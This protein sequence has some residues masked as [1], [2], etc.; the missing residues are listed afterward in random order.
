VLFQF[1]DFEIDPTRFE[2]RRAGAPV[3]IPRLVF[4]LLLYLAQHRDRPVTKTELL[5]RVWPGRT[6]TEAS[7]TQAITAARRA[8]AD[9]PDA[10][11]VI[12]T[13]HGRG[14]WWV[15]ETWIGSSESGRSQ[16]SVFVGRAPEMGL[17]LQALLQTR[18]GSSCVLRVVGDPGIGKSTF[19]KEVARSARGLGF[20]VLNGR[21]P[22]TNGESTRSPWHEVLRDAQ[23]ALRGFASPSAIN[24]GTRLD[25]IEQIPRVVRDC[26]AS[27]PTLIV[28]DDLHRVDRLSFR[29]LLS[30]LRGCEPQPLM[31]LVAQREVPQSHVSSYSEELRHIPGA[32]SI[33]LPPL[34]LSEVKELVDRSSCAVQRLDPGCLLARSGG[35]PFFATELLR[36]NDACAMGG[37]TNEAD[38]PRTVR[39]AIRNQ[40]RVLSP[41]ATTLLASAAVLGREFDASVLT[42][43]EGERGQPVLAPLDELFSAG[44]LEECHGQ[45][46][47]FRF[48]HV[49]VREAVYADLPWGERSRLHLAAAR[50]IR[51]RNRD[52]DG[53]H[54]LP[55]AHH[56]RSALPLSSAV[57]VAEVSLRAARFAMTSLEPEGAIECCRE[58][59]DLLEASEG[60]S[61]E[62]RLDL[63]IALAVAQLRAGFRR[64][65]KATLGKAQSRALAAGAYHQVARAA[66]SVAPGFFS[67]ETGVVNWDLISTLEHALA[68]LPT[69]ASALR[70]QLLSRLA[71]ALYWSEDRARVV[72]LVRDAGKLAKESASTA[73]LAYATIARYGAL[74]G[75][76]SLEERSRGADELRIMTARLGDAE[77]EMMGAVFRLTTMLEQ[78]ERSKAEDEMRVLRE[79]SLH[80]DCVLGRWYP[81]M[82]EAMTAIATGRFADAQGHI[83]RYHAIGQRLDDVNVSQTCLLQMTEIMWQS[84]RAAQI[85][86]AVRQN[87]EANPSLHEWRAAL[88]FLSARAGRRR[89]AVQGLAELSGRPLAGLTHRM[90]AVIGV[91]ALGE[92][93]WLLSDEEAAS[94][95]RPLLEKWGDRIIVAGYGVLSWGSTTRVRGHLAAVLGDFE[96]AEFWYRRALVLERRTRNLIWRARTQVAYARLLARRGRPRDRARGETQLCQAR[97]FAEACGLGVLASEASAHSNGA[98]SRQER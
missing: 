83:S 89:E 15:A 14:Y 94:K 29:L 48:R 3:P 42:R 52:Q 16:P 55:L 97:R 23:L 68:V 50:T 86:D 67:I 60:L 43:L 10:Q 56:L 19:A 91:A 4:D 38:L 92:A 59:L 98:E 1:E 17:A 28:L 65:A 95:L 25:L 53:P 32:Q 73:A 27:R 26:L 30:L 57:E 13:V 82:Y 77:M 46:G 78:G 64:D 72:R 75:P 71:Q 76:E 61:L 31:V 74:W 63:S 84:G 35:N 6:V 66:L 51:E 24:K 79:M 88:V 49:L 45:A 96:E 80:D 81:P 47:Y 5:E 20:I 44:L 8:V 22:E 21:C 9:T 33:T 90:N 7:L 40:I 11:R 93:A 70:A 39:E 34:N 85:V 12:R 36:A 2:L 41:L 37:S 87:I 54:L 69:G 58:A 18:S 62:R